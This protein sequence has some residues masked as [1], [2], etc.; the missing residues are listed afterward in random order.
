MDRFKFDRQTD[1]LFRAIL[2]LKTIREAERFFRDLCT[3]EEL[4]AMADR[5]EIA[6]LVAAGQPYREIAKKLGTSTATVSRVADWLNNGLG[7]Y[8]L[9]LSRQH[10]HNPSFEKRL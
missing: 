4:R 3:P 9:I 6:R 1:E 10:H 2:G 7:G 5:W 8:R